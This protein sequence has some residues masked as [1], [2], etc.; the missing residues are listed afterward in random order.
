[1]PPEFAF[2]HVEKNV[3]AGVLQDK[4]TYPVALD[5]NLATWN[6]FGNQYWQAHYLIDKQ[7]KVRSVH[8]GEGGY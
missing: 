6:A 5:N 7:G 1:M 8:F 4:I 2:E 3:R